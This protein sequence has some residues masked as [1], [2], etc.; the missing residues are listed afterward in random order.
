[1]HPNLANEITPLRAS[2][3]LKAAALTLANSIRQSKVREKNPVSHLWF[4]LC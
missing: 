2:L 4:T 3:R 1:M